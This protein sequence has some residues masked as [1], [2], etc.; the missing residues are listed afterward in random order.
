MMNRRKGVLFFSLLNE[1]KHNV[2]IHA[3]FIMMNIMYFI[4]PAYVLSFV[5]FS[6]GG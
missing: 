5:Y 4:F 6:Q 2:N 3:D 1:L